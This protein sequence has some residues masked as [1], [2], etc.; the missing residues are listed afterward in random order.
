MTL[1]N[2]VCTSDPATVKRMTH[3]AKLSSIDAQSQVKKATEI[4]GPYG[5][6]WGVKDLKYGLIPAPDQKS[7]LQMTLDAVFWYTLPNGHKVE[8]EIATDML[9]NP[10]KDLR[11]ILL[12]DLTTKALSKLGFNS[13]VFEGRFDDD[14]YIHQLME[15]KNVKSFQEE[16]DAQTVNFMNA[17]TMTGA[18]EE[19]INRLL[20]VEG[21]ESLNEIR[22]SELRRG[23]VAKLKQEVKRTS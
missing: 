22:T 13:D 8:F 23:F 19:E 2:Q 14:K 18:T 7:Y 20:G 11:K 12:T 3:G 16:K 10:K 1:W 6:G 21:F 15:E 17:V 5:F 4:F 9:F